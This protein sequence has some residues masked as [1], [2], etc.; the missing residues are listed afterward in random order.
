MECK[1]LCTD[2]P[3]RG[4]LRVLACWR[5]LANLSNT[6]QYLRFLMMRSQEFL[7]TSLTRLFKLSS[8]KE[9]LYS[10]WFNLNFLVFWL[11]NYFF[12]FWEF[13]KYYLYGDS[14]WHRRIL[15]RCLIEKWRSPL[16]S[17]GKNTPKKLRAF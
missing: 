16:S 4:A 14:Q 5:K 6:N 13:Y 1:F 9:I 10:L 17:V 7:Q 11:V 8:Y 15:M 2:S 12:L 3:P